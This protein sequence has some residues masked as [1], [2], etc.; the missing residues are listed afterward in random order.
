MWAGCYCSLRSSTVIRLGVNGNV[1][2]AKMCSCTIRQHTIW[3]E[4]SF[5][6]PLPNCCMAMA[7]RIGR[8]IHAVVL[9]WQWAILLYFLNHA[10]SLGSTTLCLP[11]EDYEWE[12][13]RGL[14]YIWIRWSSV[15]RQKRDAALSYP[16][17]IFRCNWHWW[18]STGKCPCSSVSQYLLSMSLSSEEIWSHTNVDIHLSMAR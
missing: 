12:N 3:L 9:W 15:P 1:T 4:M 2:S 6:V 7:S 16:P 13:W 11:T 14:H 17:K 8:H 10:I 5:E 18:E